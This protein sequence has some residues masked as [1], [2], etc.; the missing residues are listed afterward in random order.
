MYI[1][2]ERSS[3]LGIALLSEMAI[4][5]TR[6]VLLFDDPLAAKTFLIIEELGPEWQT[7]EST[8]PEAA[9][10]L[11]ICAWGGARYIALN[12]PSALTRG[13]E[14]SKLVP[15]RTFVDR[16]LAK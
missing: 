12:P 4:D 7:V 2:V 16:L 1:F 6:A 13:E 11:E 5:G 15:I 10:L 3:S 9:K 14:E 8:A